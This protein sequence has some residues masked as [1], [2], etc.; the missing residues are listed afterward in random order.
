VPHLHPAAVERFRRNQ[1]TA[2]G[3]V[4]A[5]TLPVAPSVLQS[6]P[7]PLPELHRLPRDTSMRYDIGQVDGGGRVGSIDVFAHQGWQPQDRLELILIPG[8]IV[9]RSCPDGIFSVD[10]R[11]RVVIPAEARH[12]HAIH[13]GDHVLLAAAADYN[14]MIIYP[15]ST[16]DDMIARYHSA[17]HC[18]E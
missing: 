15:S 11:S 12:R 17:G 4:A 18:Q 2:A 7:L 9:F 10:R 14:T 5:L 8:A 1:T 3:I 6:H 13:A 16:L